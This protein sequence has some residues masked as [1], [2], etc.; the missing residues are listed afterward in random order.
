MPYIRIWKIIGDKAQCPYCNQLYDNDDPGRF[1]HECEEC[2][3][4]MEIESELE[5]LVVHG[6]K[7]LGEIAE[8]LV[9]NQDM[10]DHWKN[11]LG[12]LCAFSIKP[13]LELAGMNF[14]DACKIGLER[15]RTKTQL[16]EI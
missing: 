12:D 6:V 9:K 10:F 8:C 1:D 13:M 4:I 15:K 7:E 11:E 16:M 5:T 2:T 3:K 14:E